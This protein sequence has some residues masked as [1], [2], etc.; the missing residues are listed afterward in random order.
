MN[1]CVTTVHITFNGALPEH[2]EEYFKELENEILLEEMKLCGFK[3][4]GHGG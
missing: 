4:F 1:K 2:R 3:A